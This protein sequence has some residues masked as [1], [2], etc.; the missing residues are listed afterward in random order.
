MLGGFAAIPQFRKVGAHAFVG[1]TT[2]ITQD[3][4]PFV[5]V[6]G[7]PAQAHGINVE[8]LKRRGFTAQQIASIRKAYKLIYRSDLTLEQAII[9]VAA[10]AEQV[11]EAA[12]QLMALHAFLST[13]TRGI[14]R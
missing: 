5:L 9:A 14:V 10:E 12:E 11:P 4:P 2:S 8:G 13:T 3:V 7:N 6:S 1:M